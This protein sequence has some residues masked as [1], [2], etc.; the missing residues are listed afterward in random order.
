MVDLASATVLPCS[1]TRWQL[2]SNLP[3]RAVAPTTHSP[4]NSPATGPSARCA[5]SE[6]C[7]DC[8]PFHCCRML[9]SD[10]SFQSAFLLGVRFRFPSKTFVLAPGPETVFP[11][12]RN[13]RDVTTHLRL[14][15]SL[16]V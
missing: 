9:R 15:D 10:H 16:N 12:T 4:R 8:L 13:F 7:T 1:P 2:A 14:P 5:A 6:P 11:W 3:V